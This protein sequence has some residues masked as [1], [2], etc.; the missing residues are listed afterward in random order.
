MIEPTPE[1]FTIVLPLPDKYLHP[2]RTPITR[3]GHIIRGK[4]TK[5]RRALCKAL[6]AAQQIESAPWPAATLQAHF[7]F[8][9]KRKRDG[10]NL[11]AWIKSTVD[12]IADSGIVKDDSDFTHLPSTYGV[13]R[14]C[15]RLEI[16]ITRRPTQGARRCK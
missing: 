2:N 7:L 3:K 9:T 6:A 1:S 14:E 15:P 10:D 12:G 11:T 4:R 8:E 13:D 5:E 16:T